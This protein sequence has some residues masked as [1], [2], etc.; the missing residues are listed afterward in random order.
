[1]QIYT[2]SKPSPKQAFGNCESLNLDTLRQVEK[3]PISEFQESYQKAAWKKQKTNDLLFNLIDVEGSPLNKQYWNTRC[4]NRMY[5]EGDKVKQS[6]RCNKRWCFTCNGIKSAEMINGYRSAFEAMNDPWLV[7]LTR[8]N[9]SEED[10]EK[11]IKEINAMF[12][13]C[14]DSLKKEARF[15]FNGIRVLECTYKRNHKNKKGEAE[16]KYSFNPHFHVMVEGCKA[17]FALVHYW[18]KK[19]GDKADIKGQDWKPANKDSLQELFKYITK[20]QPSKGEPISPEALD[21]I[22]KVFAGVNSKEKY[23]RTVAAFGKVRKAKTPREKP[24]DCDWK[25]AEQEPTI[26]NF[27]FAGKFSDWYSADGE[28]FSEVELNEEQLDLLQ[29]MREGTM[30]L[31]QLEKAKQEAEQEAE[32]DKYKIM[33]R[34]K[35]KASDAILNFWNRNNPNTL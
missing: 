12:L 4:R 28:A 13:K 26:F 14:K 3:N 35:K 18:L 31:K 29:S 25:E 2:P 11:E 7:T 10:I 24:K 8:V 15:E 30:P 6:E 32:Q 23:I 22:F 1:M 19:N 20:L 17:A 34:D 27:Q 16:G 33:I 21:I 9:V 5:L